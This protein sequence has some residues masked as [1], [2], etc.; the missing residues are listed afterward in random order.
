MLKLPQVTLCC[1]DTRLPQLALEAMQTSMAQAQFAAALLFTCPEHGLVNVPDDI[2]IIELDTIRSI[3]DYSHF[4]LKGM[5]P[6]LDTSHML[7][8]QWDGYVIDPTMWRDD[9]LAMDYIG[10]VWPQFKDGHR[11]GNGGFSLRSRRLLD[12]LAHD[13]IKPT[14]PED[15]CIAR[16]YRAHLERHNGIRFAGEALAHQFAFER[17]RQ[18]PTSFGFHGMSNMASLLTQ[19]QLAS[20]MACAPTSLFG[21]TEA[22][23]FIKNLI[24][25]KMKP[26][27]KQALNRRRQTKAFDSA[28]FRLW[29]RWVCLH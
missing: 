9:Y 11:V 2:Q 12:A 10:A 28:D 25:R 17:D 8:V 1:V 15:M 19:P 4:L 20:F 3:E 29:F 24:Q 6:Y 13:D 23:G 27:A 7:I 21:S 16:T 5:A 22:R 14:H 18:A 26:L